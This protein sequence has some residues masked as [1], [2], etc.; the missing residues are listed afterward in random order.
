MCM[1]E[2]GYLQKSENNLQELSVSTMWI[3]GI[4][5]S[6]SGLVACA[7]TPEPSLRDPFSEF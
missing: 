7:F 5:L 1:C 4:E 3:W 2:Q 6:L